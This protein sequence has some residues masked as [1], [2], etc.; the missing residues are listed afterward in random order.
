MPSVRCFLSRR[1]L[2]AYLGVAVLIFG[3]A[4]LDTYARQSLFGPKIRGKPWC[5]WKCEIRWAA[6][7]QREDAKRSKWG[8]KIRAWLEPRHEGWMN[9]R[10]NLDDEE[11][12]PLLL[13]LANDGDEDVRSFARASIV[14][15]E[16]LYQAPALPI[17]TEFLHDNDPVLRIYAVKAVWR[18]SKDKESVSTL[19]HILDNRVAKLP[20]GS[21]LITIYHRVFAL[22][23]FTDI[24]AD[25]PDFYPDILRFAADNDGSLRNTAMWKM[26][27]FGHQAIPTLLNGLSDPDVY[28]RLRAA[29]SLG[30]LGERKKERIAC[31]ERL[32]SSNEAGVRERAIRMLIRI[33]WDRFHHLDP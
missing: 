7:H 6:T 32:V 18:I 22:E 27:R 8:K 15:F 23:V 20:P 13:E 12:L 2:L 25:D 10:W 3:V 24:A 9:P 16:K 31:L 1:W 5:Y 30:Q 4:M 21:R 19:L 11:M 26:A 28:V 33:D 14:S 17:V 29:D